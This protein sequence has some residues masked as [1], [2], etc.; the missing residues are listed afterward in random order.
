MRSAWRILVLILTVFLFAT[1]GCGKVSPGEAEDGGDAGGAAGAD[2][3]GGADTGAGACA[4]L[5][6]SACK[7]RSDCRA[8]YCS[9]CG[10]QTFA[11]CSAVNDPRLACPAI[12]C[13]APCA[14]VTTLAACEL[15]TD[16]HAVFVDPGNCA[17]ATAGCCARFSRCADGDK[18]QCSGTVSCDMALPHC[19]GAFVVS[20]VSNCYEG[21]VQ[22][23]DCQ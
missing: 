5:D 2:G 3:G 21:C 17:C 4:G 6:E 19:E 9:G 12:A 16:C 1:S 10:N 18:A 20:Y 23:K 7:A 8:D 22:S 14:Q 11:G 13:I 15:R